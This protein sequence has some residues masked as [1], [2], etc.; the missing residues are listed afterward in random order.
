MPTFVVLGR[1]TPEAKHDMAASLKER[2][3]VWSEF[4]KKGIKITNYMTLGQFDVV[5]IIESPTE[6]LMMKFLMAAGASGNIET[7]TLRAFSAQ[8][9]E[10]IRTA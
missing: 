1:L 6:E 10:R 3:R 7:M 9:M 2:D 5:N 8:E 4:Q